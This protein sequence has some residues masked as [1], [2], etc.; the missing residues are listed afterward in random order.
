MGSERQGEDGG[1]RESIS[2]QISIKKPRFF[3]G[4]PVQPVCHYLNNYSQNHKKS[5]AKITLIRQWLA[6]KH[7]IVF[8]R[9]IILL[10]IKEILKKI[11]EINII[12]EMTA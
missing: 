4:F 3:L 7:S 5:A 9:M 1:A 11:S 8:H 2:T 6:S 12:R 10:Y